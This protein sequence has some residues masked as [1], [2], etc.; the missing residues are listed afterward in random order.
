MEVFVL[1][2]VVRKRCFKC[3][4]FRYIIEHCKNELVYNRYS[5]KGH[6]QKDCTNP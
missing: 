1:M 4:G 6:A 2:E 3:Q 5:M